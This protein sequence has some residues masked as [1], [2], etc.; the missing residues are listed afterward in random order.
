MR[1]GLCLFGFVA[2]AARPAIAAPPAPPPETAPI[3]VQGTQDRDK[4]V[5]T[6]IRDL[7]PAPVHGQLGRFEAPVC[8]AVAGVAPAQG[9]FIVERLR[10]IAAAIGIP[11]AKPRCD[12][13]V[14]VIVT[15][16]KAALLKKLDK[17]R[18]DYFPP[19]WSGSQIHEL[20]RDPS[21]AA[22][23]QFEQAYWADG[24]PISSDIIAA[25]T[26]GGGFLAATQ[27]TTEPASR[28]KPS[29]RNGFLTSIVVVQRD[30]LNGLT[31]TQLADYAA[32]R[33]FVRTDPKRV[34]SSGVDTILSVI[35]APMGSAVPLTLT[36]WDLSFLKAFYAS[37]SNNYAEYQRAE[38]QRLMKRE[39]DRA[40]QDS[41]G[42]AKK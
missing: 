1:A 15:A 6:F 26:D 7:T 22:A 2:V 11:I 39:L 12:A 21:P 34:P 16:D 36:N 31:T 40:E 38:M 29:A 35:D 8:P 18:H 9:D 13:N 17:Q 25:G 28:L 4:E 23:W 27:R 37:G 41:T 10:R 32:M 30:A 24:R 5:R 14:V 19:D 3:I 33:A 42:E 20:Q